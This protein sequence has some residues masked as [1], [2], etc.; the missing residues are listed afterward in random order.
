MGGWSLTESV[1]NGHRFLS[2]WLTANRVGAHETEACLHIMFMNKLHD[3]HTSLW[4]YIALLPYT[5]ILGTGPTPCTTS[6]HPIPP[7]ESIQLIFVLM[8]QCWVCTIDVNLSQCNLSKTGLLS[9]YHVFPFIVL[10]LSQC[11]WVHCAANADT[12]NPYNS[13]ESNFVHPLLIESRYYCKIHECFAQRMALEGKWNLCQRIHPFVDY[14]HPLNCVILSGKCQD[15][16]PFIALIC[17][18]S[19]QNGE[20]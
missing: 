16:F 14:H 2:L 18:Q 19:M 6:Y 7:L 12:S 1:R 10:Y 9:Q 5:T 20:I 13:T 3:C 15:I 4:R 17:L 11:C 8:L